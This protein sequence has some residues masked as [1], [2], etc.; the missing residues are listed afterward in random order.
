[1]ALGLDRL[2]AILCRTSTIRDVIAFP[3]SAS[4]YD[5]VFGS[6]ARLTEPVRDAEEKR[7]LTAAE[8]EE[9]EA[10]LRLY[11]LAKAK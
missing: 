1:M 5:P 11:G 6:P 4:G 8:S 2:I 9:E 7:A 3:K 10:L